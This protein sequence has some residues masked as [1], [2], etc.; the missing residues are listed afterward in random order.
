MGGGGEGECA[1]RMPWTCATATV[2]LLW[3]QEFLTGRIPEV[4]IMLD[5]F[6]NRGST[7]CLQFTRLAAQFRHGDETL[8]AKTRIILEVGR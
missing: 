2:T 3:Q 5:A 7:F 6:Y 4:M 1:S 8:E